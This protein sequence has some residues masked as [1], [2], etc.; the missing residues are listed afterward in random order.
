MS[1]GSEDLSEELEEVLNKPPKPKIN[2]NIESLRKKSEKATKEEAKEIWKKLEEV[3]NQIPN[4]VGLTAV[5]LDPPIYKKVAIVKM[6]PLDKYYYLLNSRIVK[7]VDPFLFQNEG[8]LSLPGVYKTTRRFRHIVVE[9]D[10]YGKVVFDDQ[11]DH[12]LVVVAVQQEIDHMDG[13]LITD[14]MQKPHTRDGAKIGRNDPCPCGSGKKF[15]KC[16]GR[17]K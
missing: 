17:N 11:M 1:Y 15:K 7:T 8:C 3:L 13:L 14:R 2:K 9:D 16:C 6:Y 5:Q 4:G 10:N 12:P